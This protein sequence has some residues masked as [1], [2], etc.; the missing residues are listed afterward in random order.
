[1]NHQTHSSERTRTSPTLVALI[2]ALA[3][4]VL[5]PNDAGAA[6]YGAFGAVFPIEEP[7]VL[8]T[9]YTRLRQM[10]ATGELAEMEEEMQVKAR[11]RINRPVPVYG[12]ARTETYR[13]YDV[14]LTIQL[15][16]DLADHRGVVFAEAGT[17]INPLEH[18]RC[19]SPLKLG[20]YFCRERGFG[21]GK[22][23]AFR[24]R[25]FETAA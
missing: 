18:S 8:E 19:L 25:H 13:A 14:D 6:D 9:I 10:E 7:S 21:H 12:M 24:R 17:R 1:M 23:T 3:S 20:H 2:A 15:D 4:I 22:E 16:R 11:S 5:S